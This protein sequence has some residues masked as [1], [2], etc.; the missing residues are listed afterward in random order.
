MAR[1]VEVAMAAT[2]I[3]VALVAFGTR[4]IHLPLDR[5][6]AYISD[7]TQSGIAALVQHAHALKVP[8]QLLLASVHMLYSAAVALTILLWWMDISPAQVRAWLH[9]QSLAVTAG[10]IKL[11]S[12][13]VCFMTPGFRCLV[14]KPISQL[15][16]L[17]EVLKTPADRV[18]GVDG[19]REVMEERVRALGEQLEETR[20]ELEAANRKVTEQ[21]NRVLKVEVAFEEAWI[22]LVQGRWGSTQMLNTISSAVSGEMGRRATLVLSNCSNLPPLTPHLSQPTPHTPPLTAHLSHPTSHTPP[23]T[24]HLSH[25]TS[26]TPPLTPHLSHP[27]SHTPPLTPHHSHPTSHTPP[28]TPHLSHPTSHTPPLTPHLSHPT[29]HTP[30]LTPHLSHPTSHTPPLTPHLSHPTSHTP[31][32]TPHLYSHP[33][34]HTPPLTPHLSHPT[35]HTPPLTPHLSH[36]TSHTPPLT[37]HLSH[38]TSHTPPLTPHLS[39]P[40]AHRVP[41]TVLCPHH[42]PLQSYPSAPRPCTFTK[43]LLTVSPSLSCAVRLSCSSAAPH[44]ITHLFF[45]PTPSEVCLVD[46]ITTRVDGSKTSAAHLSATD[47]SAS[48][49]TPLLPPHPFCPPLPAQPLTVSPSLF[50]AP[51]MRLPLLRITHL[52][53]NPTLPTLLPL[54]SPPLPPH[55]TPHHRSRCL[56]HC[57]LTLHAH[58]IT[59]FPSSSHPSSPSP[60][61]T[62][63][64]VSPSLSCAPIMRRRCSASLAAAKSMPITFKKPGGGSGRG[65]GEEGT[66]G[67]DEV[68]ARVWQQQQQQ[69]QHEHALCPPNSRSLVGGV[70]GE[71]KW[72]ADGDAGER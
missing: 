34:S 47:S 50:C 44:H 54:P 60:T 21:D 19:W 49:H 46:L 1:M 64:T 13:A 59:P 3:L 57:P 4:F 30:P 66:R 12:A 16:G 72:G 65:V 22:S 14:D 15:Q 38:P 33:T 29:S 62:Q 56:H 70:E 39:H 36:P 8:L 68:R 69:Q 26:H 43:P 25:P 9:Q 32:L 55:P 17:Y 6:T 61:P 45:H 31:P 58:R 37:P 48:H 51:I 52:F 28:L 42:A 67:R 2:G 23:L 24:P 35:S 71:C 40:T 63:L 20:R 5:T 10:L 27:T 41:V 7:T 53:P 11:K 18:L